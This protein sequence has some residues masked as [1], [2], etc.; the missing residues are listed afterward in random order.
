MPPTAMENVRVWGTRPSWFRTWAFPLFLI[1]VCPPT[2]V[3]LWMIVVYHGGSVIDFVTHA[4]WQEV[5]A[6]FPLPSGTAAKISPGSTW[7]I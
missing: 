1:V 7:C 6:R 2:T 3:A 4:S 5:A